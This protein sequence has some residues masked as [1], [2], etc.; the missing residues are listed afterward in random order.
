ML[1]EAYHTMQ[2]DTHCSRTGGATGPSSGINFGQLH[3]NNVQQWLATL[4]LSTDSNHE[5]G[6]ITGESPP[7]SLQQYTQ[8]YILCIIYKF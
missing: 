7:K 3:Q 5:N 1:C 6:E 4:L 8:Y 2:A